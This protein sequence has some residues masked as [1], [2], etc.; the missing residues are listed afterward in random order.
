[1]LWSYT[2]PWH[3]YSEGG[4]GRGQRQCSMWKQSATA[5]ECSDTDAQ[6]KRAAGGGRTEGVK[7]LG[8]EGAG[9]ASTLD[10][11]ADDA[12]RTEGLQREPIS[13]ITHSM[14]ST[15]QGLKSSSFL[16]SCP[17]L[18]HSLTQWLWSFRFDKHP[19][20]RLVF[21]SWYR[22]SRGVSSKTRLNVGH[23]IY[24]RRASGDQG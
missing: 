3:A 9:R 12:Y 4:R 19:S 2:V 24:L 20:P 18:T 6:E 5:T 17:S 22:N 10:Q 14:N 15:I 8:W 21:L 16:S 7:L 11:T 13:K 23:I 1:M